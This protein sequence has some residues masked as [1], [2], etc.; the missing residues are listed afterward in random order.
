MIFKSNL[1]GYKFH[2]KRYEF[3]LGVSFSFFFTV[4]SNQ[5]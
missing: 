2:I 4:F 1:F 5:V 3:D